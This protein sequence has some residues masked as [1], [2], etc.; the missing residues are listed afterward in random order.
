MLMDIQRKPRLVGWG[1]TN[2]CNLSCPHC[3]S[4]AT[5]AFK[6][7]LTSEEGLAVIDDLA[8]LGAERIGWTG[9]EPLLRRDLEQWIAAAAGHGI[10]SGI[11]T[12]GTPLTA[13]RAESLRRAGLE[14]VQ[15]SLD[16]STAERNRRIR[17]AS[18]TDF[19][20]VLRAVR[21][22]REAGFGV[23]M[24]MLVGRETL[25][26]VRPYLDLAAELGVVSVRFCGYVPWGRGID[27]GCQDRLDL[28]GHLPE[29]RALVEDLSTDEC[30]QA[31]FDPGFGPLPP[32]FDY[33]TCM[34]GVEMLYLGP[35]GN[36]YPC[37]AL[38]DDRFTV[39]NVKQRSLPDIWDDP[40][41]TEIAAYPRER[42]TGP[43]RDCE[44]FERCGGGCRGVTHAYTGDLDASFPAC[45]ASAPASRAEARAEVF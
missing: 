22:A 26:D 16:G 21:L 14:T 35:E 43:C 8:A 2:R 34:A 44:A 39:G 37:T 19:R 18:E 42:I 7:E 32:Y 41:M 27:T 5:K 31:L 17:G 9:G 29:L 1:I 10:R 24:A 40:A 45:L 15:I 3:Y 13:K 38:L 12:N 30:P 28:R 6:E 36:V 11:T 23:H 33:H 4:S 25:D 20:R